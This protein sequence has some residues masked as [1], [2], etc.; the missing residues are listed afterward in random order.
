[1]MGLAQK[2]GKPGAGAKAELHSIAAMMRERTFEGSFEVA[3]G[4]Y[5]FSYSLA[6]AV[7][8]D[9]KLDIFGGLRVVSAGPKNLRRPTH[10]LRNVRATLAAAQSGIGTAPPRQKLPDDISPPRPDLPIVESTGPLSFCGVLYFKL[11]PLDG[12]TLGVPADM[13]QLQLN[14]R[15]APVSNAE[16][17]LQGA[18]SSIV[19]ALYGKSPDTAAADTAVS[20]LNTLLA[21]S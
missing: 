16:R 13:R 12:R 21:G 2:Q 15:L 19:D 9:G 20:E 11:A 14:V 10:D 1:M 6:K 3:G 17:K 8:V 18:F 4:S 5:K 7:V